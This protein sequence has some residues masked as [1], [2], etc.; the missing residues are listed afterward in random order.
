MEMSFLDRFRSRGLEVDPA[1]VHDCEALMR[2]YGLGA[3][4]QATNLS[5]REDFGFASS[6]SQGHWS[7]VRREIGRRSNEPP[8][9]SI[10]K[11]ID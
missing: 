5:W 7:R 1:V 2:T 8:D 11:S 3:Y 4:D 10:K 6:P 9:R